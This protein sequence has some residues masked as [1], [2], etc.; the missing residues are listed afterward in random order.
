[1]TR[2]PTGCTFRNFVPD[3]SSVCTNVTFAARYSSSGATTAVAF[4]L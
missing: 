3:D 1:V 2:G 4:V